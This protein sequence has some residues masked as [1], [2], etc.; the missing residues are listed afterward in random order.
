M[1]N[2]KV[3][4]GLP[5]GIC[6]ITAIYSYSLYINSS[7]TNAGICKDKKKKIK[8][9]VKPCDVKQL[10]DYFD[11]TQLKSDS[12]VN[13]IEILCDEAM[14]YNFASICINSVHIPHA[15]NY[16]N[17]H[18]HG[19]GIGNH[20]RVCSVIG[21]PLGAMS[22]AAKI[23]E[24]N[25]C[26]D[27]G[28]DEIDMVI[29][30]G[31]LKSKQF[32]KVYRDIAGVVDTCHNHSN[33][34]TLCKV[35]LETC[36]LTA[37]EIEAVS[38]MCGRA[39]ADY[40]KTS[41]GFSTSGAKPGIVSQ[42]AG[43][44]SRYTR[45]HASLSSGRTMQVKA[46]GGIRDGVTALKMIQAGYVETVVGTGQSQSQVHLTTRLGTSATVKILNDWLD[47]G[48]ESVDQL[49]QYIAAHPDLNTTEANGGY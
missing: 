32:D 7:H 23:A 36:L 35:I 13:Q 19:G 14:K 10:G 9:S 29:Q 3:C 2:N 49:H 37:D 6:I 25:Y 33:G 38:E 47:M 42:M 24:V 11:H 16:F 27:N 5:I 22:T 40:I 28:A 20:I 4:I 15:V 44:A 48:I 31:L 21:F 46:S 45:N 18:E 43:I 39:G 1:N 8:R 12:T 17:E 34:Y 26:I 30:V 41:T